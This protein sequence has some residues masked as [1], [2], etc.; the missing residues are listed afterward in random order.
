MSIKYNNIN[1]MEFHKTKQEIADHASSLLFGQGYTVNIMKNNK[2]NEQ[3]QDIWRQIE[4]QNQFSNFILKSEYNLSYYGQNIITID[5]I[6]NGEVRFGLIDP[7][8]YN[9]VGRLNIVD[10]VSA[11]TYRRIIKDDHYFTIKEYWTRNNV[12]RFAFNRNQAVTIDMFNEKVPEELKIKEYEEHNL[13]VLPVLQM[14]NKQ[15]DIQAL[16]EFYQLS[17]SFPV[18]NQI[19]FLNTLRQ[20]Q[21]KEALKNTTKVFGNF[22]QATIKMMQARGIP[23]EAQLLNDLFIEVKNGDAQSG[24]MVEVMQADPKFASYDEA[25]NNVLKHIWR[26]AGYT[27]VQSGDTMSGNAETLYANSADI[28]TTKLK[29]NIRQNDYAELIKRALIVQGAITTEEAEQIEIIFNIKENVVQSPAQVVD[30]YLR[31]NQAGVI[32]KARVLQKV[33]QLSTYEQAEVWVQE[34]DKEQEKAAE[35]NRVMFQ[36]E[37]SEAEKYEPGEAKEPE[38][39]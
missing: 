18:D 24:K 17:D 37:S 20:Q 21:I 32:D 9:R 39:P 22:T 26:G 23:A 38:T 7:N 25:I 36:N 8:L 3:L 14:L 19:L 12:R 13:G 33:E 4:K 5:R 34:A 16:T 11:I 1:L 30:Q 15:R 28:R 6:N 35:L 27:Y 10:D 2:E 29:R 31:L